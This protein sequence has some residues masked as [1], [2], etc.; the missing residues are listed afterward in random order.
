[1]IESEET[2]EGILEYN[3]DLFDRSTIERLQEH[4]LILLQGIVATPDR[5]VT[6]LPLLTPKEEHYLLHEANPPFSD[7]CT[8]AM[9]A[10]SL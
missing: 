9:F 5:R 1:M 4:L 6:D 10:S 2:F 3:S 8:S 7:E